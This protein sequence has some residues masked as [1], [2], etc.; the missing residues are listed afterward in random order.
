MKP[1][2][3]YTTLDRVQSILAAGQIKPA[4]VGVMPPEIPAVWLST[5]EKWEH[6]AT[7]RLVTLSGRARL[8]TLSGMI[9]A[10][11]TLARIQIDPA[12]VALIL[13]RDLQAALNI[14]PAIHRILIKS[15]KQAGANPAEWRAVAG[16]VPI[17]AILSIEVSA[18]C[19]P[20]QWVA[21]ETTA[22][23]A[24]A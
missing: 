22:E 9:E 23:S 13:A 14:P 3:H 11:A 19:Q 24:A 7:K 10:G 2:F 12:R 21:L 8:G 6:T 17:S 20:F 1:V 15:G 5:A 4:T 16:A 18:T